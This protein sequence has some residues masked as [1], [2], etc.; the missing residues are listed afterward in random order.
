[1]DKNKIELSAL[2]FELSNE[3]RLKILDILSLHNQ[4]LKEFSK[5]MSIPKPEIYRNLKRLVSA[6]IIFKD[7]KSE[8]SLTASGRIILTQLQNFLFLEN[9]S[10]ILKNH[11]LSFLPLQLQASIGDLKNINIVEGTIEGFNLTVERLEKA[12]KH[13][14]I[15]TREIFTSFIIQI[16][17]MIDRDVEIKLLLQKNAK[18]EFF[19]VLE[20]INYMKN[21]KIKVRFVENVEMTILVD[22]NNGEFNLPFLNAEIDYSTT[23]FAKRVSEISWLTNLFNYFWDHSA[24]ELELTI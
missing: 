17:K 9:Y 5:V 20:N 3:H 24:G 1:M 10:E 18:K 22:E 7:K 2:L 8:Y 21:R 6:G 23:F 14:Y 11:D 12:N 16:K 4:N 19:E 13:E 15:M